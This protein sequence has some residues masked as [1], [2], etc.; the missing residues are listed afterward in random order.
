MSAVARD[1]ANNTTTSA[2]VPVTVANDSSAPVL[3]LVTATSVTSQ[4]AT[5]TWTTNEAADTQVEYGLTTGYGTTTALNTSLVTSHSQPLSGL[6]AG[7]LYHF[8]VK[9]RD[10]AGNLATSGDF[11]FTTRPIDLST[12]LVAHWDFDEGAGTTA[13]DASGNGQTGTL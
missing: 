6:A 12:G 10:A 9:S 7:T 1:G 5:V 11:T 3:S 4:G 2:S 8:R 13:N